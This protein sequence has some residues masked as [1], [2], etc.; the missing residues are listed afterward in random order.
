MQLNNQSA[1]MKPSEAGKLGY[2][3]TKHI[4]EELARERR[5]KCIEDYDADPKF[6]LY[7]GTKLTF[8]KRRSKFCNHS[9]SAQH[10]NQG[11]TRHIKG[12]KICSCGNAKIPRNKYC[13]ECSKT[14][15]YRQVNSFDALRSD[16][17]RKKWLLDE[18]GKRCENCGLSEWLGKPIV[19]ELHHIDGN[20]DNS[21]PS[22]LQL[23]CP[24][25]HSQTETYKA[26]NMGGDS[27]RQQ[28]RRKRY[29]NGQT[30]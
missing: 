19:I 26:A 28:K 18:R 15:V 3:K 10:N 30:W 17:S 6:C 7:C 16:R 12:S 27:S 8:E 13:S 25:C 9:C 29:A 4:L 1:P 2:E 24:N 23:I 11:V 20:A 21:D 14:H 22:N 5:R